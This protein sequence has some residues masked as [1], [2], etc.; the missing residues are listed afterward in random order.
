MYRIHP[1]Q[2]EEPQYERMSACNLKVLE[3]ET[4]IYED[5]SV[6]KGPTSANKKMITPNTLGGLRKSFGSFE[7]T[8]CPIYK[9]HKLD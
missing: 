5:L 1:Q 8:Q 7:M 6:P 4:E 9:E 3:A 2:V